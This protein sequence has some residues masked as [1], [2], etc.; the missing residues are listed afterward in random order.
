[1][2]KLPRPRFKGVLLLSILS[3]AAAIVSACGGATMGDVIGPAECGT[4]HCAACAFGTTL[5]ASCTN[6]QWQCTCVSP[7]IASDGGSRESGQC[8]GRP[9]CSAGDIE[10]ASSGK[11]PVDATCYSETACGATIYC[12]TPTA[13]C[14]AVPRCDPGDEEVNDLTSCAAGDC[15]SRTTCGSTIE[16]RHAAAWPSDASRFVALDEGGGEAAPPPNMPCVYGAA[17]YTFTLSSRTLEWTRCDTTTTPF[18]KKSGAR[19]LTSAESD[20]VVS[21]VSALRISM[22]TACGADKSLRQVEVRSASR[23]DQTFYDS[24]YACQKQGTYV[25][26]IDS[27]FSVLSPLAN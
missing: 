17:Q 13:T 26:G 9:V 6:G 14:G 1:M 21:Q 18:A 10:I 12:A 23:G 16:C 25:D 27:L 8:D 11:C 5:S 22:A 3:A 7:P 24:F 4:N 2:L 20:Q 15:Y 19:T